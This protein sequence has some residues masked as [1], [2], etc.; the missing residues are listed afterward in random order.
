MHLNCHA[1]TGCVS[2]NK[3]ETVI[4]DR[5]LRSPVFFWFFI[6]FIIFI[7]ALLQ[8]AGCKLRMTRRAIP[9][10]SQLSFHGKADLKT[11]LLRLAR[12]NL[13]L[14]VYLLG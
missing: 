14:P 13:E 9:S 7:N 11:L 6:I 8:P 12:L 5:A 2:S 10:P 3:F 4:S 1:Q